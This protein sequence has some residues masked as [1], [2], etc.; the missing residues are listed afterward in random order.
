MMVNDGQHL[1]LLTLWLIL[2]IYPLVIQRSELD[3]HHA[4]NGE[5]IKRNIYFYGPFSIAM[6]NNQRVYINGVLCDINGILMGL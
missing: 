6:L 4:I 1:I 5:I 2:Y 3:N